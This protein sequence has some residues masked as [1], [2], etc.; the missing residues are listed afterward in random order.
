MMRRVAVFAILPALAAC[1]VGPDY[2][3]PDTAP[4]PWS[5]TV[6]TDTVRPWSRK[7]GGVRCARPAPPLLSL[8]LWIFCSL[9]VRR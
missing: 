8:R 2:R 1:A 9:A 7:A 3:A 5:R 4:A 6:S